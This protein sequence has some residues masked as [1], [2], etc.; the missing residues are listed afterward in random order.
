[1]LVTEKFIRS[2]VEK[3]ERHIVYKDSGRWHP[4][5]CNVLGIKTPSTFT[6]RKKFDRTSEPVF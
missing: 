3:Y 4:E 5:A 2:L 1:M 6:I